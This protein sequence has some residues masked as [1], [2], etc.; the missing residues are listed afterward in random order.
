MDNTGFSGS[1]KAY[2]RHIYRRMKCYFDLLEVAWECEV[3]IPSNVSDTF[4][5]WLYDPGDRVL[6]ERALRRLQKL[7]VYQMHYFELES[8]PS[9]L[10]SALRRPSEKSSRLPSPKETQ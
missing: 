10:F 6:K 9:L 4:M 3:E 5:D 8:S 1:D 7:G 2:E